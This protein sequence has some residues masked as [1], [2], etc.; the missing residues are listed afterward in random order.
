MSL[1][2]VFESR[3]SNLVAVCMF[4]TSYIFMIILFISAYKSPAK[5]VLLNI[6]AF[7]E[8][9]IEVALI[10]L[11]APF[12]YIYSIDAFKRDIKK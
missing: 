11:C 1:K 3:I 9:T 8:A 5:M 10:L 12:V 7:G 4:L 6:N 2:R